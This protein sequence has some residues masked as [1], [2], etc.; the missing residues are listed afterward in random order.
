MEGNDSDPY[1]RL[2]I[3]LPLPKKIMKNV[4]GQP[5]FKWSVEIVNTMLKCP[6]KCGDSSNSEFM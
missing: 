2:R 4:A 6:T 5:L 3:F 1:L